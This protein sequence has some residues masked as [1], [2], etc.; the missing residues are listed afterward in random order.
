MGGRLATPDLAS[1]LKTA[2]TVAIGPPDDELLAAV[3]TAEFA[4]RQL[5]VDPP[6]IDYLLLRMERSLHEAVALV[7]R[8][9]RHALASQRRITRPL[10]AEI[11]ATHP[12]F[13]GD[14]DTPAD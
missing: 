4:E 8:L 5:A 13:D 2:P 9:D 14:A 3:L 10:A 7:E 11:L 6:V 1:R 12:A